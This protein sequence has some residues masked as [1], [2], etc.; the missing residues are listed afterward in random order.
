MGTL[1]GARSVADGKFRLF[2]AFQELGVFATLRRLGDLGL[3]GPFRNALGFAVAGALVPWALAWAI[4]RWKRPAL[5][6]P[7]AAIA[8]TRPLAMGFLGWAVAAWFLGYRPPDPSMDPFF[9]DLETKDYFIA[10]EIWHGFLLAATLAGLCATLWAFLTPA[11]APEGAG[12][13]RLR[14]SKPAWMMACLSG[15]YILAFSW[16][17]LTRHWSLNTDIHDLGLYDQMVW[18]LGEGL[19]FRVTHYEEH[20]RR[21]GDNFL[22]EHFMPILVLLAPLRKLWPGAEPLLIAQSAALGL[23]GWTLFLFARRETRSDALA[24]ALGASFLLHPLVQQTNVKDFHADA[25]EPVFLFAALWARGRGSAGGFAL[26]L[27]GLFLCK[28]DASLMAL[29]LGVFFLLQRD[30]RYG[31]GTLAG[32]LL[33]HQIAMAVIVSCRQGE[34]LRHLYRYAH[35][36]PEGSW[37]QGVG[38]MIRWAWAHPESVWNALAAPSRVRSGLWLLAPVGFVALRSWRAWVLMVIP[39]AAALLSNWHIQYRLE[40]HYGLASLMF[41]YAAAAFGLGA[42]L[43]S[44]LEDEPAKKRDLLWTRRAFILGLLF[45]GVL[46][47]IQFGR[48][49]FAKSYDPLDHLAEPR[50]EVARRLAR[51]LPPDAAVSASSAL[52]VQITG[53][54]DVYFFPDLPAGTEFVLVDAR[55][56]TDL[57]VLKALLE[58]PEWGVRAPGLEEG[59]LILRRGEDRALNSRSLGALFNSAAIR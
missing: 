10:W 6:L 22:A 32:A 54:R 20:L 50:H 15:A 53:R 43:T 23:A 51:S 48:L 39:T 19:G 45:L 18:A 41:I 47:T 4:R 34:P 55:A 21:F 30:W 7:S 35:L 59:F 16:L 3:L 38:D 28:E 42:A 46:L 36:A 26:F 52:G 31:L 58:S 57:N 44:R 24:M 49:P 5:D 56:E 27:G 29:A 17:T 9:R 37:P 8:L 33:Y 25:L 40:L 2:A 11:P 14:D 12:L 1:G 13:P